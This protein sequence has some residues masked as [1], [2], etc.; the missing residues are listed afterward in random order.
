MANTAVRLY[1]KYF[2]DSLDS[3]SEG[4]VQLLLTGNEAVAV[5]EAAI[6][7]AAVLGGD[8]RL[9]KSWYKQIDS[10]GSNI[11]NSRLSSIAANGAREAIASAVGLA[12]SR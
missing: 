9:E 5:S 3:E 6:S 2:G 10:N 1:R 11:F 12:I 8:S 7:E 4:Q